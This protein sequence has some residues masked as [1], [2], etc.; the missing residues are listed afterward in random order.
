MRIALC[1]SGQPRTWRA[2][3][4]SLLSLFAGHEVDVFLHTWREGDP[5][6]LEAVLTAYR[7][8]AFAIETRPLFANQKRRLT[9]RFP[10]APPLTLFDMLHSVAGSL[11]LALRPEHGPYDLLARVRFDAMF[12]DGWRG[13]APGPGEL[14]VLDGYPDPA[15]VNDQFALGA[16]D[17]MRAYAGLGAWLAAAIEGLQGERLR[18]EVLLRADL[19]QACGLTLKAQPVAMRLCRPAQAGAAFADLID[20]PL[21]HAEK[22]EAWEAFA[23]AHF[24]Q[25]AERADFTHAGRTPL[26]LDRALDSWLAG[27]PAQEGGRLLAAPW[28]ERIGAVDAFLADQAGA[29]S[30]LDADS[31]RSVR[32][33][34]AMLLQRMDRQAPMTVESFLVHALSANRA[35]MGRAAAWSAASP[36]APQAILAVAERLGIL[37]LA[38]AYARPLEQA[39]MF[40]WRA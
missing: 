23:F 24:P 35:D 1:L 38:L 19:E 37:G 22:H 17:A 36:P 15:G 14:V 39:P 34:C 21:F 9:E 16:P 5:A 26:A 3:R 40:A 27:R 4:A 33:V 25:A 28:T 2:T 7:P 12:E 10:G 11:A 29:P 32:L 31:Y 30:S 18:P 6:E 8:R 13:P 20:D